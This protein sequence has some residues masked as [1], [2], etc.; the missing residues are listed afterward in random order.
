[1][2]EATDSQEHDPFS[3]EHST[4]PPLGEIHVNNTP[5]PEPQ[6]EQN[7]PASKKGSQKGKG[8]RNKFNLV[9][10]NN[11]N[12]LPSTTQEILEDESQSDA[13]SA[14]DVAA[15]ELRK[16]VPASEAFQVVMDTAEPT[17]PSNV[18]AKEASRSLSRSPEK[19]LIAVHGSAAKTPKFDPAV[20]VESPSVGPKEADKGE[21]SFMR[22]IKSRTPGKMVHSQEL[23]GEGPD[24]FVEDILSRSPSKHL[25][26]LEDSVIALDA[27]EEA[28]EQTSQ[29]LPKMIPGGIESPVKTGPKEQVPESKASPKKTTKTPTSATRLI[30]RTKASG[31]DKAASRPV[32]GGISSMR[33]DI[34]HPSALNEAK[35]LTI[36]GQGRPTETDKPAHRAAS[37]NT[38]RER[39]RLSTSKPGFVPA[40]S[41]KAPTKSNFSLPGEA[42]AAKMKAQR[43]E[44]QKKEEAE[45]AKKRTEFKARPVPKSVSGAG[46]K[47]RVSSVLP[48]ETATSRA[49]MS[50]MATKDRGEGK[51]NNV[52]AANSKKVISGS[53]GALRAG[54]SVV[55]KSIAPST[56]QSRLSVTK[57]RTGPA[58]AA[59]SPTAPATGAKKSTVPANSSAVRQ[60]TTNYPASSKTRQSGV[61]PTLSPV[62]AGSGSEALVSDTISAAASVTTTKGTSKGKEVFNRGKIA[63][64][65]LLRQKREK[66]EAA[67]KARAAAAER[68]RLAS[69]EW[70]EKQRKK[71]GLVEMAAQEGTVGDTKKNVDTVA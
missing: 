4:R 65:E 67:K 59:A 27:L 43:E 66:E 32:V 37:T 55:R 50:L 63:E 61:R 69:R 44:R 15:E 16:D 5:A 33:S 51:E 24:S 10:A 36:S 31:A 62:K 42:Y 47:A 14:A 49:R 34:R 40:K 71:K 8:K 41:A 7:P 19:R 57:T 6:I 1:M 3:T 45:A 60:N 46:V 52:G 17:T 22:S 54:S 20:H 18:A 48:R 21:D 68:G 53:A 70:A 30:S 28:I 38:V 25:A 35:Q 64:E 58:A 9:L 26:R 39:T 2:I 23:S 12:V 29:G 56:T 13:S 11:E